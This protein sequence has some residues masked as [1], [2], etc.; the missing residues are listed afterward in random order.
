MAQAG[1]PRP[2]KLGEALAKAPA[3]VERMLREAHR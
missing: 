3:L 1:G 2:E